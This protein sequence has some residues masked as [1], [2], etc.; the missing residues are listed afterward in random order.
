VI[1][2]GVATIV[3][4]I[5]KVFWLS[6]L[7]LAVMG[8][9]DIVGGVIRN[10]LVQLNTPDAMRGRVIAIQSVFTTTSNELGAFESGTLAALIGTVGSVVAGGAIA[11]A[12]AAACAQAFPALRRADRFVQAE[13]L[14]KS[15]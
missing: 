4:A 13:R 14:T 5:S 15:V 2:F 10:G 11:L 7:A 12:V 8:A 3:F 6:L 9:F 1:G